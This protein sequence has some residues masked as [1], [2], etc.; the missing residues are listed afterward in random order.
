VALQ[1]N[2]RLR[3]GV[4]K[5]K[6]ERVTGDTKITIC[7]ELA[8]L[9]LGDEEPYQAVFQEATAS[10]KKKEAAVLKVYAKAVKL[11]IRNL[12]LLYKKKQ[13]EL[14]ATGAGLA[15]ASEITPGS[16]L[17]TLWGVFPYIC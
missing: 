1:Q 12:E 6:G 4:W 3:R 16:Q 13:G 10:G 8:R 5:E 15:D 7:G 17:H 14:G 2:D 11:K 9:I